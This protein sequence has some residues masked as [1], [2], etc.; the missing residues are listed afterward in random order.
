MRPRW[1]R[2]V[3]AWRVTVSRFRPQI[4]DGDVA[5]AQRLRG[6]SHAAGWYTGDERSLLTAG[7]R[8]DTAAR[9]EPDLAVRL[10]YSRD[11]MHH[12]VGWWRNA[13]YEYCW[14]LSISA[15]EKPQ[16]NGRAPAS[17]ADIPDDELRYW[18]WAFFPDDVDKIWHEPGG[19]D[20]GLNSAE[21]QLH[22]H[23]AH[24]RVFLHPL[25]LEP[26]IPE[27]E[28]YELTRWIPALT[29]EKVDR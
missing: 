28:V 15:W 17:P 10:L 9:T 19:T 4:L 5:L 24:Q 25:T 27:G 26:F 29:P 16:T 21:K 23:F 22:R 7:R 18:S 1:R 8:Y 2:R 6:S 3:R 11:R 12:S 20:P 14:H 13:N